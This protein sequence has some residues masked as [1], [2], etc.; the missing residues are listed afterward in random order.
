[1]VKDAELN[2]DAD[3]KRS[4][5]IQSK[6]HLDQLVYQTE[7]T[8]KELGDKVEGNIKSDVD[9][10]LAKAKEVT[11]KEDLEAIKSATTVLEAA[12]TKLAE[13]VY[14]QA[15]QQQAAA[16]DGGA[17]A[18]AGSGDKAKDKKDGDDVV[19]ADFKEV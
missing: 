17:Q 8:L 11:S 2:A 9:S 12:N 13:K 15:S 19:D 6:N 4:E 10:A 16:G 5:L 3:K 7:K 1:M 14:A 18:D